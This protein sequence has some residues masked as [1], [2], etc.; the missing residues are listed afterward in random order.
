VGTIFLSYRRA[1]EPDADALRARI[2]ERRLVSHSASPG[3]AATWQDECR[4][5]LRTA[6]AV[7]C[8]VGNG[9]ALSPNVEWEL[10]TALGLGL[11]VV[12]VRSAASPSPP[13]PAPLAARGLDLVE[14]E[15]AAER[16]D[17]VAY[18]RAR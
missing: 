13:L 14:L 1:E 15:D 11:P 12:G 5:L 3:A 6:S 9:T 4:E 8:I 17:E 16:L 10:E 2:G 7:V 18:E